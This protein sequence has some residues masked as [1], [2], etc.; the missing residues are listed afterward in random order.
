MAYISSLISGD[1]YI[2]DIV[3]VNFPGFS[4]GAVFVA[5]DFC[6]VQKENKFCISVIIH[7]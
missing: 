7:L 5:W 2:I 1:L 4:I 6:A 3:D